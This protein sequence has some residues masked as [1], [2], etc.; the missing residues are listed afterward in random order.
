MRI[1]KQ[2]LDE[3]NLQLAPISSTPK[4]DAEV[5][6]AY[7]LNVQRSYLY[8]HL[9]RQ[10]SEIEQSSFANSIEKRTKGYPIPYLTGHCEFW[11][12]DLIVTPDTLIPRPETELLV[13]L[14]LE[15]SKET[16][17]LVADLG[18]GSGAIALA[19][20]HEKPNWTLYATDISEAALNVA[21]KNATRLEINNII[22]SQGKWC[23]ALPQTRFD[24]IVSNPPYIAENDPHL[25]P[26]VLAT[27]P[28]LALISGESGLKDIQHI[29]NEAKSYL[30]PGGTLLLEHGFSQAESVQ[31][32][33]LEAGYKDIVSKQDFSGL[34]RV[35]S[36][37]FDIYF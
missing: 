31:R 37:V 1:V 21:K 32:K 2:V 22:F 3:A 16:P 13:E 26:R 24:I 6:L 7:V 9:D 12:L 23:E 34:N 29:I 36:G 30:K 20:A 10:L 28:A 14:I 11:S 15:Y 8:A 4:L 17:L 5:L 27:E 25:E 35:T 33:F 18:T 19:L